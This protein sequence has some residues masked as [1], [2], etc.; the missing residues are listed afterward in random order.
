MQKFVCWEIGKEDTGH[1]RIENGK[2]PDLSPIE[3]T[4]DAMGNRL[5]TSRNSDFVQQMGTIWHKVQQRTMG[6]FTS[7]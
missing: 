3:Y 2:S 6:N 4:C 7:H 5:Q 1:L